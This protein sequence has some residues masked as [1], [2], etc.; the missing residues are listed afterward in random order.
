MEIRLFGQ[1]LLRNWW[2]ILL[3]A[4]VAVLAS[5]G[6]SYMA[7]PQYQATARLML[8]PSAAITTNADI[9]RSLDTLDRPSV[10]AT[11]V[12]VMNSK[13]IF[14]E[15]VAGLK[16]D[17]ADPRLTGYTVQAVVLPSSSILQLGV[18]GPNPKVA[19]EL[20]NAIGNQSINYTKRVNSVYNMEFLDLASPST[21]PVSPQPMRDASLALVLGLVGGVVLAFLNEQIRMP[22]EAIRRRSYVDQTSS[23]FNRPHFQNKL[24]DELATSRS[25]N[26]AL[27]L[28]RLEGLVGLTDTLPSILV[29]QVFHEVTRRLRNE[30][31][32]N[33]IVG[34]WSDIEFAVMLPSTP[35]AASERTIERIRTSLA[36]PILLS[37]TNE[38]VQLQPYTAVT[39]CDP[40]EP[41]STVIDRV[42]K[43]LAEA[44]HFKVAGP[45]SVVAG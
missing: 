29:Q 27:G 12:E 33:D 18:T 36:E 35:G 1:T 44:R 41:L 14:D 25:G 40:Q 8:N 5:L 38:S 6:V 10:A 34:R 7:V 23:A 22:L 39:I 43:K 19:A 24:E 17:P 26:T 15:A 11:Y 30:L 37:A 31:R 4:L 3:V 32:G 28:I 2:I 16:V 20:A 9:V 13:K 21:E 45:T 42:E